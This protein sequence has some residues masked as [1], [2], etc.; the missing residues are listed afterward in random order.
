MKR[1][2]VNR[3]DFGIG[4]TS[5]EVSELSRQVDIGALREY[6]DAVGRRTREGGGRL[7]PAGLGRRG[8]A[9]G[10][11][12][13]GSRR[14]VRRSD[15]CAEEGLPRPAAQRRAEWH[16]ALSLGRAHG[17][18]ATVRTAGGFGTGI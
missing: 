10:R 3:P 13:G 16:R 8:G 17:E 5:P 12:A 7:H 11:R 2:G 6:R 18:A 4:M 9:G 15:R 14:R 1:L